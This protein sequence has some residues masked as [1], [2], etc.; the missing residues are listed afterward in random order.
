MARYGGCRCSEG[1]QHRETHT[2]VCRGI[3][4][5]IFNIV[6][7]LKNGNKKKGHPPLYPGLDLIG[8]LD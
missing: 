1:Y 8:I 5:P 4:T 6:N 7:E 2:S 3:V